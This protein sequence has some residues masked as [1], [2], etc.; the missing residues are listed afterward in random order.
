MAIYWIRDHNILLIFCHKFFIPLSFTICSVFLDKCISCDFCD[1]L[2]QV[3]WDLHYS[4][5]IIHYFWCSDNY[6]EILK[7]FELLCMYPLSP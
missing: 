3:I 5:E 4:C 2:K 1:Y 7:E 6:G